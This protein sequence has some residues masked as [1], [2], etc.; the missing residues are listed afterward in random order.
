MKTYR[1]AKGW[2]IFVYL[3]AIPMFLIFGAM[4]FLPFWDDGTNADA[5]WF[6]APMS[7][8][9]MGVIAV[10][11]YDTIKG[12]VIIG[13]NKL[14]KTGFPKRELAFDEIKG[15]RQEGSYIFIEPH[16]KQQKKIIAH[17]YIERKKEFLAWL[18]ANYPDLK[19]LAAQ[20]ARNEI[21]DSDKFG[22]SIEERI[23]TIQQ[24]KKTTNLL[25]GLGMIAALWTVFWADPYLYCVLACVA[26]FI[27]CIIVYKRFDNIIKLNEKTE[28]PYPS[29]LMPMIFTACALAMRALLNVTLLSHRPVWIPLLVLTAVLVGIILWKNREFAFENKKADI[30]LITLISFIVMAFNYGAMISLNSELDQSQPEIYQA[31]VVEKYADYGIIST[32]DVTLSAWEKEENEREINVP[33]AVFHSFNEGDDVMIHLK[34]GALGIDWFEVK[35]MTSQ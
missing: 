25:A 1:M 13:E 27:A 26:I 23:A 29:V 34:S 6:L 14:Y 30:F 11:L 7:I 17:I 20:Q 8:L 3:T 24:V 21:L 4:L 28:S 33:K 18:S 15:Y 2:R 19:E 5:M 16:S 10:G 9:M 31:R 12:K 32:Y 22:S 35:P